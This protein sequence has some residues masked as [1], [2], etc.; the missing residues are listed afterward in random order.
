MANPFYINPPDPLQ[1]LM[2][3]VQGYEVASKRRKEGD[4]ADARQSIAQ[5][6]NP[7]E[8]L[9]RLMA[10]GDIQGANVYANMLEHQANRG[11]RESEAQR[12]QRNAD[13][14]YG[15]EQQRLGLA[16]T[17][18]EAAGRGYDYKEVDDGQGGKTLVR[19]EKATGN[20]TRPE[21]PGVDGQPPSPYAPTQKLTEGE[22][23]DR[24]YVN[25]MT[26]A[27]KTI[28]ELENINEGTTGFIGGVAAA[29]PYIRD[30]AAFNLSA[31]PERQKILQAQRNF[32]NATLRRESGAVI[33]KEE[34]E[35]GQRQYF[36]MPGDSAEVLEQKRRNRM[37]T[38]EG[39]MQGAGRGYKPPAD[40]VGTKGPAQPGQPAQSAQPPTRPGGKTKSGITWSVSP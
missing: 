17:Q 24:S 3:G 10:A 33:N 39:M 18:A 15:L 38:I 2:M 30:S 11:F 6:G 22:S 13:R 20:I 31:S 7:R 37:L 14:S 25:R 19:I 35:N 36:P 1:A 32:I 26:D 21:I 8:A 34:F 23:K 5:G 27:H 29:N 9:Q 40:Y 16:K 4:I 12:A 28:T